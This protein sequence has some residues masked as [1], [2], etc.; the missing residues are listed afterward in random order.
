MN[1]TRLSSSFAAAL[2]ALSAACVS[3]DDAD[4]LELAD[5]TQAVEQA[6]LKIYVS[7][8]GNDS[9][10]GL[11]PGSA[12]KTLQRVNTILDENLHF[13]EASWTGGNVEVR[14][15][16]GTYYG[17]EVVWSAINPLRSITF[18]PL[19][20]D[21]VRPV[22][23]GCAS[24]TAEVPKQC[25]ANYFFS[26][27]RAGATNL[28]FKYI[29]VERYNNGFSFR[30]ES[31]QSNESNTLYGVYLYR[32]GTKYT[33]FA[34][35]SFGAL[36]ISASDYNRVEN[37]HFINIESKSGGHLHAI[38]MSNGSDENYVARNRFSTSNGV[39]LKLRNDNWWNVFEYNTFSKDGEGEWAAA[40]LDL[41]SAGEKSSCQSVFRNNTLDGQY[42]CA[43]RL[44][45]F[46]IGPSTLDDGNTCNDLINPST[47]APYRQ[48]STSNNTDDGIQCNND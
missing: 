32:I 34:D 7:P 37:S 3:S 35:G 13:D 18:L 40:Y 39:A 24:A 41:P 48:L 10:L 46:R 6:P 38:Y 16:P 28:N 12:V 23:N 11:T 31:Y 4:S 21:N 26:I 44:P 42:D 36:N 43:T 2:A 22:F 14:I 15:A 17:Q 19:N 47:G 25:T 9:N 1:L 33:N 45:A 30:G 5:E 27:R 29:R 8:T 20:D